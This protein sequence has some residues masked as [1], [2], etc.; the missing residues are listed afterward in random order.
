MGLR[1][2]RAGTW[3]LIGLLV[4]GKCAQ[5]SDEDN[6]LNQDLTSRLNP[7]DPVQAALN[8]TA[9]MQNM[10]DTDAKI[11][12]EKAKA[13]VKLDKADGFLTLTEHHTCKA[14]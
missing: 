5:L 6:A 10:T 12:L 8:R 11:A 13:S 3:V 1:M 7:T 14:A 2:L 9:A 4:A